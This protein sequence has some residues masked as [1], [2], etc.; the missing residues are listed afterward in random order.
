[1]NGSSEAAQLRLLDAPGWRLVWIAPLAIVIWMILLAAFSLMLKQSVPVPTKESPLEARLI[2]L[3]PPAG[4]Q[5]NSSPSA[6][7]ASTVKPKAAVKPKPAHIVRPRPKPIAKPKPIVAPPPSLFGTAKKAAPAEAPASAP[8]AASSATGPSSG[9]SA[10]AGSSAGNLGMGSDNLGAQALFAP[11]P[12][13]P[14]DL[15]DEPYSAV[16]V[17]HF[18]VSYDGMVEVTLTTPTDNPRINESLLD[19]LKQ[20]RFAPAK[21]NGVAINS[22]FD[23]RIPISID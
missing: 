11:T 6:P 17:A 21:K 14:D 1:M 22:A 23:L 3:P 9:A 8:P 18:T 12:T 15:R 5:G 16:A 19:A 7:P 13:I 4:L 2:E 20:W 10:G